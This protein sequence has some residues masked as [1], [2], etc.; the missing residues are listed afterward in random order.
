MKTRILIVAG[1]ALFALVAACGGG[2][3]GGNDDPAG[4]VAEFYQRVEQLDESGMAELVCPESRVDVESMPGLGQIFGIVRAAEAQGGNLPFGA[5]ETVLVESDESSA[6]VGLS[7][8]QLTVLAAAGVP[9][10]EDLELR[11]TDEGQWCIVDYAPDDPRSSDAVQAEADSDPSLPGEHVDLQAI[12]DGFYGNPDGNNT[13]AHV[14]LPIDYESEQGLPPAGGDHWGSTGCG[15]DPAS[16]PQRCGPAPWGIF[17]DPWTAGTL[18][19]NMEHGGVVVWY[20]TTDRAVIDDLEDLVLELLERR[21]IVMSPYPDMEEGFVAI[22]SWSRRLLVPVEEY[23]RDLF[24]EFIEVHE[25]R[26]NPESF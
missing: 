15:N 10:D 22:T 25:R 23:D 8:A 4:V 19:H 11:R 13:N 1:I 17:A 16:A 18:V 24:R 3:G 9:V 21:L 20:N 12:Y 2:G 26:F 6:T 5:Y 7:G 14:H